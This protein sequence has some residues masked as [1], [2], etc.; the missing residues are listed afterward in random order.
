MAVAA[1][2]IDFMRNKKVGYDKEQLVYLPMRGEAK[3]NYSAF[4]ECLLRDPKIQGVTGIHQQPTMIGSSSIAS[5]EGQSS[6]LRPLVGGAFVDYDF[7]ETMKIEMAAGRTFS[8][9][10]PSDATGA[11]L[12]NEA[13]VKL[14]GL[15]AAAAVGKKFNVMGVDG[16]IIGVVRDF[17]YFS[18]RYSI[19][20]LAIAMG[21]KSPADSWTA[22]SYAVVRLKAG[23]VAPSLSAVEA[24]WRAVNADYPFEYR[25]FDQD[26]DRMY[27]SDEQTGKILRI[28]ALLAVAIACLGLFGLASFTAEQKTRE[29]GVRKVLG[30]SASGIVVL[31]TK[32]FAKWVLVANVL[33]W[34]AAYFIMRNWLQQYAY[35]TNIAWWLFA[36][37]GGGALVVALLTVSF[38]ALRAAQSDPVKALKYE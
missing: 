30:A 12:V 10:F 29:I 14:M 31:L 15:D 23:D 18:V 1:R 4:K 38:Q 9:Q 37:A 32:E 7:T 6:D 24:A 16:A 2:Q 36:A 8:R 34:P 35:R 19:E 26:F 22:P 21:V 33:A 11:F 3:K 28:F 27:R 25:F 20:P 13:V 17:H 5:W